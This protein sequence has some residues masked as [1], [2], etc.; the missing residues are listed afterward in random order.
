[1]VGGQGVDMRNLRPRPSLNRKP[2][3]SGYLCHIP[4]CSEKYLLLNI[5]NFIIFAMWKFWIKLKHKQIFPVIYP[6]TGVCII[7]SNS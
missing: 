7:D 3:P 1:M 4:K 2:P 5:F 6:G